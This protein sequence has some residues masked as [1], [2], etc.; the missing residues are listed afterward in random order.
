MVFSGEN[1]LKTSLSAQA[2]ERSLTGV[3]ARAEAD[4]SRLLAAGRDALGE[5]GYGGLRVDDVLRRAGMSTRAFYRHFAGKAD[6]FLALFEE[7]S[8]RASDRL[9][10]EVEGA[11]EP[12]ARLRAWVA[13]VLGLAYRPRLAGRARLFAGEGG[14]LA[15]QF[16]DEVDRATRRQREPL[17]AA[18]QAGVD[19][20]DFPGAD[21]V[22]DGRAIY[23]L[24]AGLVAD[25]LAGVATLSYP[26]AVA[27]ATG[28]ALQALGA[29]GRERR[30]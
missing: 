24:C 28:F 16:P 9:R 6:L 1:G 25:Q 26:E 17:E 5:H 8:V 14:S 2:V 27:L 13:A 15:H 10:A 21:P 11:G 18:I 23:H 12:V 30:P 22:T 4:V 3:R 20:G 19:S 7:E 29:D